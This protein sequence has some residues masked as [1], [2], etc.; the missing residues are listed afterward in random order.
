MIN[1]DPNALQQAAACYKCVPAGAQNEVIIYL[2]QQIAGNTQTPDQL[3]Q[4]AT[5]LRCVPQG[6]LQE[7]MVYLLCQ[8]VNQ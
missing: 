1:C 2:L 4:S 6:M 5:C 3:M 7:V 8:I